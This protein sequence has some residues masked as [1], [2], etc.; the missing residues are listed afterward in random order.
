MDNY[1]ILIGECPEC[2]EDTDPGVL[3]K[4]G[5]MCKK[6]QAI[7]LSDINPMFIPKELDNKEYNYIHLN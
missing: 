5:G 7:A 6:C 3:I 2:L 1:W 4:H